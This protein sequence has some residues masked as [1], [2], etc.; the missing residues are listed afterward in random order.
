M[1]R[2]LPNADVRSAGALLDARSFA[3]CG[4]DQPGAPPRRAGQGARCGERPPRSWQPEAP[5]SMTFCSLAS[6]LRDR[7]LA[8]AGRP[9]V[10]TY[11]RKVFI[12][13]TRL[14]RD[15]CHYCTFAA[16]PGDLPAPYLSPDEVLAIARAGAAE[17]C[18]EALFTLGD[19]PEE[20]WPQARAW[21]DEAGYASTL[22]YLRAMAVLVLGG[23]RT[24]SASEPRRHDVGRAAAPQAGCAV[25]GADARDDQRPACGL[26]LGRRTT[27]LRTRSRGAA[28]ECSRT[29]GVCRCR[30]RPGSSW[31]LARPCVERAESVLAIRSAHRRTRP[32]AGG[33]RAELPGQAQNRDGRCRGCRCGRL[34]GDG[35]RGAGAPRAVGMRLQVPPNLSE[36][37]A[38]P[39]LLAAG[40][41]DW[42][43]V[44]PLTPDHVNPER[45]W[46]HLQTLADQTRGSRLRAP[47]T[48]HCPPRHTRAAA[49]AGSTHGCSRTSTRSSTT[50]ALPVEGVQPEGLPWQEPDQLGDLGQVDLHV[51]IDTEGRRAAMRSDAENAF[52]VVGRGRSGRGSLRRRA[53]MAAEVSDALRVAESDPAALLLPQNEQLALAML[54]AEGADLD[55][56]CAARRRAATRRRRRRGHVRREP[57]HQLHQHLLH[58]LS[59]LRIRP[60]SIRCRCLLALDRRGRRRGPG[61]VGPRRHRSVSPG[62]HRPADPGVALRRPRACHQGGAS[63]SCTSTRSARWRSPPGQLMPERPIPE[64]LA[65]LQEAGLGSLPGTAAE[66]LDDDVRWV[67]T[68]GSCRPRP[69]S[70]WSSPRTSWGCPPA[71]R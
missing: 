18:K 39:R 40:I 37:D 60:T 64:F 2:S 38:L 13:L 9:G 69:G 7:G 56:V 54:S 53:R 34:P 14:C 22:D 45:P 43:G 67:L 36:L 65:A 11:S 57:Q 10:I 55:A 68:K 63:R 35:R 6:R 62:G 46:P 70:R 58:R 48:A 28:R 59:F 25:D 5:S 3:D 27:G 52:G 17:E 50:T 1:T 24:A 19:R 47:R 16:A 33:H 49:S 20:R 41:D 31:G 71:A 29:R 61:G 30:S 12:P 4:R 8:D 42:G 51:A 21:L 26:S 66:I 44:S 32:C 23:D 15:R